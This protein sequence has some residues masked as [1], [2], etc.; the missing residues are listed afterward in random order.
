MEASEFVGPSQSGWRRPHKTSWTGLKGSSDLSQW[1]WEH[2]TSPSPQ[3]KCPPRILKAGAAVGADEG[4]SGRGTRRERQ[5]AWFLRRCAARRLAPVMLQ[6]FSNHSVSWSMAVEFVPD[7]YPLA[8]GCAGP[9]HR[10][11]RGVVAAECGCVL[12]TR[13]SL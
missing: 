1:F 7:R 2:C 12:L 10:C 13:S 3:T 6:M 11:N 4:T 5:P 8:S 9:K